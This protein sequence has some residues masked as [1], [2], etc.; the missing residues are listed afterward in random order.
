MSLF[1]YVT[2]ALNRYTVRRHKWHRT[3]TRKSNNYK[4][5]TNTQIL[6]INTKSGDCVHRTTINRFPGAPRT[7]AAMVSD[8]KKQGFIQP[9][10]RGGELPLK[11]SYSPWRSL[12]NSPRRGEYLF[13]RQLTR[14]LHANLLLQHETEGIHTTKQESGAIAKMT[15]R[16]ALYR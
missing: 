11:Q 2:D 15:A 6:C 8:D 5:K 7:P 3:H 4:L 9:P 10:R 12:I 14:P 13:W 1:R 16:C